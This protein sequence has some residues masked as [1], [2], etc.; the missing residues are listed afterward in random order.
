M[1]EK[2][3]CCFENRLSGEREKKKQ[4]V[5][6][7]TPKNQ[8]ELNAI[9][10]IYIAVVVVLIFTLPFFN[11]IVLF[12][13]LSYFIL[14]FYPRLFQVRTCVPCLILRISL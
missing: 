7:N 11:Y 3:V 9:E 10:T 13:V 8:K 14:F 12:F 4:P 2:R 5:M 1:W 6:K